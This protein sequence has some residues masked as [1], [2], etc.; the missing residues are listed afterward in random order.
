MER[1]Q[2]WS[3]A[4]RADHCLITGASSGIGAALAR[5]FAARGQNLVLTARRKER[6]EILAAALRASHGV[7]VEVIVADLAEPGGAGALLEAVQHRQIAVHTLVNN[8]GFGLRGGFADA[9]W[10][11]AEA[12]LQAMVAAPLQ[13]CHGLLPAMQARGEGRI[14]NVASLAGL[15]PGLPGSTLYS[16]C[17]ALLIR[18]S[19]SLAAEN[20]HTGVRVLALCPGYVRS[21]FHAVLGV[22]ERMRQLPGLFWME[23]DVLAQQALEALDGSAVVHVPGALNGL[24]AA[25]ARWLP[26]PWA[27]SLSSAFSHRYR[28]SPWQGDS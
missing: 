13:L 7:I 25:L 5:R 4:D 22:E 18:F 6:L 28:R 19:Q 26:Q 24:I 21:E 2:P 11:E 23:A 16:A 10:P 20:R 14:L 27:V 3:P 17:K 8:A 12:M 1:R 9:S 15:V